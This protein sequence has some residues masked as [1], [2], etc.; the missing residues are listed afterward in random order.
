MLSCQR[1]LFEIPSDI[2]YLNAAANGPPPRAVRLAGQEGLAGKSAPWTRE[3]SEAPRIADAAR[4]EAARL[5]GAAPDDIA[6]V[7]A[8]SYGTATASLNLPLESGARILVLEGEH[9]SQSMEW[10]RLARE[11]NAVLEM[12]RRP[13]DADWTQAVLACIERPGAPPVGIAALTP[14]HWC[15]GTL[16][17]LEAL[18][19]AL[20]RQGAAL[21]VDATQ[22]AGVLPLDVRRLAPDFMVFPTY[23]WLLGP[24]SLAFLY[25]APARQQGRPLEQNSGSRRGTASASGLELAAAPFASGARR[26]DMGER[27]SFTALPMAT[28]ALGLINGWGAAAIAERLRGLTDRLAE[29]AP[30]LGLTVAAR[31][32]RSPH[33]IGLHGKQPLPASLADRLAEDKVFVSVRQGV[34]RVAPHVYN[35]EA[36]VERFAAAVAGAMATAA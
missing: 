2:T 34:L 8:A 18:A 35:D 32:F 10:V 3:W 5:I 9:S 6:I 11:K 21:V 4:V 26:Y 30:A 29:K 24:Y 7:C 27:D 36:D 15:D 22:A 17:D 12:V 14:L 19:P 16:V 33:I 28:A 1:E 13:A 25:V 20:R 31:K 23:K